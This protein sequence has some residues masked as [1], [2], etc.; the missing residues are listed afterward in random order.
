LENVK[1][2]DLS[3]CQY[4]ITDAGLAHLE[5]V[6][7]INLTECHKITDAGIAHL[8]NVKKINLSFCNN[9]TDDVKQR[10]RASGVKVI[11][12]PLY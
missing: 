2:I 11:G 8:E 1:V 12:Y 5:N 10:L 7:D 6:E 4:N 3:Y 9:I